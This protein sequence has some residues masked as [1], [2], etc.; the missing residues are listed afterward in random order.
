W[1]RGASSP[2]GRCVVAGRLGSSPPPTGVVLRLAPRCAVGA[3]RSWLR[4]GVGRVAE[5]HKREI[6]R[7]IAVLVGLSIRPAARRGKVDS[8][9]PPIIGR[10]S[11]P[12]PPRRL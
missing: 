9:V 10:A 3:A 8:G 1:P 6:A 5:V 7:P 12:A 11:P 4:L 2:P